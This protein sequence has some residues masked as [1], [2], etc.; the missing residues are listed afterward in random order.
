MISDDRT[1]RTESAS[2]RPK[3]LVE[4]FRESPLVGVEVDLERDKDCGDG[5]VLRPITG[6]S[7]KKGSSS[8]VP[9]V[10]PARSR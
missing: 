10:S 2:S 4:F 7:L 3:S 5:P 1:K 6:G 8:H 9:L